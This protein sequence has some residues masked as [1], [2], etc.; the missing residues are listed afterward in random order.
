M[1]VDIDTEALESALGEIRPALQADGGDLV[2]RGVT[3]DGV[4][5]V[6]LMGACGTCPLSMMTMVAGIEMIVMKRV[7][8]VAGVV[9]HSPLLPDV[10][11]IEESTA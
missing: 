9:A 2:L 8:G 4:V 6:E 11:G 1:A 7:P 10:L 5:S 3:A